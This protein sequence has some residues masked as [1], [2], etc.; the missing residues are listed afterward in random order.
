MFTKLITN[1]TKA[2][3]TVVAVCTLMVM[4]FIL[5]GCAVT[6]EADAADPE[7]SQAAT[8][9]DTVAPPAPEDD[10]VNAFGETFTWDD[11]VSISV[12]APAPYTPGE[13][14]AGLVDGHSAVLFEFVL[15]NNSDE[16][17]EPLVWNSATS[18]GVEAPGVFDSAAGISFPPTTVLLPGQTIKWNQAYS[19]LDPANITMQVAAGILHDDAIYTNA[20]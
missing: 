2:V 4:A 5:T 10:G 17:F 8:P 7:A 13:Y 3:L 14:A 15:T 9:V 11:N 16:N 20:Q 1:S 18:G 6:P 12:S 19:V